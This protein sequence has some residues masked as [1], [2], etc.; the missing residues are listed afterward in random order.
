MIVE[1]CRGVTEAVVSP[2]TPLFASDALSI[3]FSIIQ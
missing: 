2:S 3:T 1:D